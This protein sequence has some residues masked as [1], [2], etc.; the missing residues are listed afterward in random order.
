V[1]A[2]AWTLSIGL[3]SVSMVKSIHFI[4]KVRSH[5][6]PAMGLLLS[7]TIDSVNEQHRRHWLIKQQTIFG[8]NP[9]S[10]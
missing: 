3:P 7:S 8:F 6:F 5:L 2:F 1:A 4:W 9:D 10:T